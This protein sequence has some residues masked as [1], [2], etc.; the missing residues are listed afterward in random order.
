MSI[1]ANSATAGAPHVFMFSNAELVCVDPAR[2]H[3]VWPH[4]RPLLERACRRTGLNAFAE[5]EA[6]ILAG[7]SLVWLA[8]GGS[9]IEAAVATVLTNTD[10][11][12]VCVITLCAG[13]GMQ[14]W[15]KLIER[16]DA[17][18]KDE[19]CARIRIFGRQG[20]LRVLDGFEVRH[21]VMEKRL[22]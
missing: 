2:I 8:W 12:K 10:L 20:W 7:R 3:D 13:C 1:Y 21:A 9:A 19:G 5:F 16:I 14:H 15:L 18:A 17:Y 22:V 11:G 6:D 4:V